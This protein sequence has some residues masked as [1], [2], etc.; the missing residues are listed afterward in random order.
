MIQRGGDLE[1]CCRVSSLG[2]LFVCLFSCVLHEV[3]LGPVSDLFKIKAYFNE[4]KIPLITR[5]MAEGNDGCCSKMEL[6]IVVTTQDPPQLE[7]QDVDS[8]SL[9]DFVN[10]L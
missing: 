3:K 4:Y 7:H 5:K 6:M 10:R 2:F 9:C 1:A 8:Q